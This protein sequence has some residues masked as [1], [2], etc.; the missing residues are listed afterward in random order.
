MKRFL[1]SALLF[2]ASPWLHAADEDLLEPEKAFRFSAKMVKPGRIEGQFLIAKGYY[3]YRNK[4]KFS[5]QGAKLGKAKLPAGKMKTDEVYGR[6]EVYPR[7]IRVKIPVS[8]AGKTFTLKAAFQGC[9]ELGVCYPPQRVTLSLQVP[10]HEKKK[11]EARS[12]QKPDLDE[13]PVAKPIGKLDP[14][15]EAKPKAPAAIQSLAAAPAPAA[16]AA[17]ANRGTQQSPELIAKLRQLAGADTVQTQQDFLSP[18][19]AFKLALELTPEG[20]L[21]ANYTIAPQHYL[22][23]DKLKLSVATPAGVKLE[24]A[25]LPP[26]EEKND[27]NMG[28]MFVYHQSFSTTSKLVGLPAGTRQVTVEASY[29]GCSEKGICYPPMDQTLNVSVGPATPAASKAAA[30]PVP[31]KAADAS[32][33][34]K[35]MALLQGGNFWLI[36]VG[37]FSAGLLLSLTPCVFPMI[38]ILSGIIV[39]QGHAVTR[40]RGFILSLAYVVGMAVT[41]AL[42]GVAAG[43]SGTLIS[44]ALQNPWALGVGALIFVALAFSMFGF[45]ELQMPSFMQSRFSEASNRM[46]GGKLTGVFMMGAFSAL[47]VGPC[48][49]APLAGALMYI[50]QSGDVILGGIS[51]FSLALGMGVP[52]LLVGIAGGHLLPRAG[53]WMEAVKKFFG[54]MMLG[55]AIWLISPMLPE[56]LA[57]V[58]WATLLIVSGVFLKAVEPLAVNASGWPHFWKGVGIIS[59]V[60]GVAILLG[61]L[62]GSRDILQPLTVFKGGAAA[63]GKAQAE[64][65]PGFRK[66][67]SMADLDLAVQEA[68]GRHVMLDF[69]ADW[70]VSCKEMDKFTFSD[71]RVQARLKDAVLLQADVTGNSD[72]DKALLKRFGL[73]GPPGM[74]FFDKAGAEIAFRVVG[75]EPPEKFLAS[76]DKAFSGN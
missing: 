20:T 48:V 73:F 60:A 8:E 40:R 70:C 25:P 23:R 50:G 69:Y 58:L 66:V 18:E 68:K 45:Y 1:L 46:Q 29:Q 44:N 16:E 59:L 7:D 49:A 71:P 36:V 74:I 42:A 17:S 43:L 64:N 12:G 19:E 75:Y 56:V 27:P 30:T 34:G 32:E 37:F 5:A 67:K 38:P 39:G 33:S 63:V 6:V 21:K 65:H 3:L 2:L 55:I 11:T 28:K 54:V 47:I 24:A 41:Y 26:A 10:G 13:Q 31:A 35:I 4:I 15:S 53:A 51:L 52:L 22:Y 9:A 76:L 72:D 14:L 57:M 62:G 61:A